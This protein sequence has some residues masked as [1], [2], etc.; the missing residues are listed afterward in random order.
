MKVLFGDLC[1]DGIGGAFAWDDE[2]RVHK[3]HLE[4]RRLTMKRKREGESG[5]PGSLGFDSVRKTGVAEQSG[6]FQGQTIGTHKYQVAKGMNTPTKAISTPD[7]PA[8][9]RLRARK[10][11]F[12][13]AVEGRWSEVRLASVSRSAVES[14]EEL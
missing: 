1:H 13:A 9:N 5:S 11:A 10:E 6:I 14:D 3:A 7:Q 12:E 8:S 4:E 2:M